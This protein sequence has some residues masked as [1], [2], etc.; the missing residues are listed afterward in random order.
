[1]QKLFCTNVGTSLLSSELEGAEI[2]VGAVAGMVGVGTW[3]TTAKFDNV[4]V[5]S[6]DTGDVLGE[7][8]FDTDTFKNEWKDIA[9]G[10]FSVEDGALVQ[11]NEAYQVV[12]TDE[13]GDI[14]IK[15]VNATGED[16]VFAINIDNAGDIKKTLQVDI[17]IKSIHFS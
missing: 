15:L 11:F 7:Q 3:N 4:K 1:M 9:D 2:E 6:N 5:V 14:I 8:S 16:R 13:N 17:F 10:D 12:S